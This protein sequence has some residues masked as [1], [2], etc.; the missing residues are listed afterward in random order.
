MTVCYIDPESAAMIMAKLQNPVKTQFE[1]VNDDLKD[2]H[3]SLNKYS[4]A[5]EKKFK[6]RPL[7]FAENDALTTQESLVDRAIAMH[8]L[9]EGHFDVASTFIN[10]VNSKQPS[11]PTHSSIATTPTPTAS[12]EADFAPTAL[13]STALQQQ[14]S[15][16]YHILHEMRNNGNLSPAITWAQQN[17]SA[18]STRGSNLEF[19]LCRLQYI[20]LFTSSSALA[21]VAYAR[22]A[23][24][25]FGA[26]YAAQ[27]NS[28]L[29]ALAFTPNIATSPY[30]ALFAPTSPNSPD[31]LSTAAAA[32]T[33]EFC[34]LLSLSSASPLLTAVTA[35]YLAL[36]TLLKLSQ[37]QQTHRTS[38]TTAQE[39][40][41]EVPLPAAY[42]FHSV[43]VC[44]V[45]K[46]QSTDANPPVVMPCGHV[47]ARESCERISKGGRFKCPYCPGESHLRDAKVVYL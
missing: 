43:F 13:K 44:P 30:S 33:S 42:Q 39:L 27:T 18:L 46:E 34:A 24:P 1:K 35:G 31:T 16:M 29:G 26:R 6:D 45:S 41:V 22:Q 20:S 11:A 19:D 21:A 14:F 37:I 10:E 9:R 12:W 7:P 17:S 8:L 32:F 38:W 3:S 2:I 4:K 28:L 5:L 25:R 23:F 15:S 36:P 40:P 47:I